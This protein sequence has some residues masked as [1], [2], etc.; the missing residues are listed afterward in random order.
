MDPL[1]GSEAIQQFEKLLEEN[2]RQ[3]QA[4]DLS[5][6]LWYMDGMNRQFDA[7]YQELQEIKGQL[8]QAQESPQKKVMG[9]MVSALENLENKV[10][11][12][13][14][15]LAGLRERIADC[16]RSA[17]ENFKGA[18]VSA[19]DQA[20]SAMGVKNALESLQEKIGGMIADT[21]QNI[22]KVENIGHELRS[23]GGHL[24][25]AGRAMTGKETQVVD[26]GQEGRIQSVILAPMR[27][28]QKLL[29]SMNNATL[30]VIGGLEHLEQ[31]AEAAQ[32]VREERKEKRKPSI[33][34]T[35]AEKKE[36]AAA[37]VSPTPDKERKAPEAVL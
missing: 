37:R 7:V 32:E 1:Q 26:G 5:L 15:I 8:A 16:A 28:A 12:A 11:Q 9:R 31:T 6:L 21:K 23:V 22:E 3:G 34:Q 25:N 4:Q 27:A 20:V 14:D 24:R 33:R 13:R 30:A 29:S 2:G 19:L 17:V 36:E 35:L 18:G 10:Q